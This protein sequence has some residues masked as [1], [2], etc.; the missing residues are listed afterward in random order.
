[1]RDHPCNSHTGPIA[2]AGNRPGVASGTGCGQPSFT[3]VAEERPVDLPRGQ[4]R[5]AARKAHAVCAASGSITLAVA[6]PRAASGRR[7]RA[8]AFVASGCVQ[9]A[10]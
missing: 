3:R 1:M 10:V 8:M 7:V 2:A 6:L 5:S 4:P 9:E